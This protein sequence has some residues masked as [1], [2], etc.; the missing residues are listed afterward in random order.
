VLDKPWT[1]PAVITRGLEVINEHFPRL[2]GLDRYSGL[3]DT[4]YK[5]LY[6]GVQHL[7]AFYE[8][9]EEPVM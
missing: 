4:Q 9:R 5:A 3:S 7:P 6:Q 2:E 1:D 8:A